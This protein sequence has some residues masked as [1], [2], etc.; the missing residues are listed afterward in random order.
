M[1]TS[2]IEVDGEDIN[3]V[4][5]W[6]IKLV[7]SSTETNPWSYV[8][9]FDLK[10]RCL[11]VQTISY[12]WPTQIPNGNATISVQIAD[13]A[14]SADI[15]LEAGKVVFNVIVAEVQVNV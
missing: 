2:V 14:N 7:T 9:D 10:A 8:H 15:S 11:G 1:R 6:V 12:E 13:I 4:D 3:Y 5:I